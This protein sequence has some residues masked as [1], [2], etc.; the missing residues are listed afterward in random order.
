MNTCRGSFQFLPRVITKQDPTWKTTARFV[1]QRPWISRD[2]AVGPS[3][4]DVA[5]LLVAVPKGHVICCRWWH[6]RTCLTAGP[7]PS[8]VSRWE[9]S[10]SI[11]IRIVDLQTKR[12]SMFPSTVPP[13]HEVI[14]NTG[15]LQVGKPSRWAG[16]VEVRFIDVSWVG[17]KPTIYRWTVMMNKWKQKGS[18]LGGVWSQDA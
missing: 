11:D 8:T 7:E 16:L 12:A 14:S 4:H 15:P 17:N 1:W 18:R 3:M 6:K 10:F 13:W 5:L 9:M 2:I